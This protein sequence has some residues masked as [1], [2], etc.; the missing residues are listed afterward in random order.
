MSAMTEKRLQIDPHPWY[1]ACISAVQ[2][3]MVSCLSTSQP[4][5]TSSCTMSSRPIMAANIS[6]VAPSRERHASR[7][8]R[9][10]SRISRK[11]A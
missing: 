9:S 4:F 2:P 11:R 3:E 7:W 8:D 5:S 6:G 10:F 1:V